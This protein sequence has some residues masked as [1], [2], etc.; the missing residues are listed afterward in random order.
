MPGEDSAAGD[1]KFQ[2]LSKSRLH[3]T[4]K[5]GPLSHCTLMSEAPKDSLSESSLWALWG[6]SKARFPGFSEA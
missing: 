1:G 2:N 4:L 6:E 3:C 5:P